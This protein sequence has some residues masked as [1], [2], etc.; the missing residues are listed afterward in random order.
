MK[1]NVKRTTSYCFVVLL[2][3]AA[4]FIVKTGLDAL[5]PGEG[6]Q[7]KRP[8][9][10]LPELAVG[11]FAFILNERQIEPWKFDYLV[12][13]IDES[14]TV[15]YEISTMRGLYTMPDMHWWRPGP[16][17][18]DFYPDMTRKLIGC[19]DSQVVMNDRYQWD[20]SGRSLHPNQVDDIPKAE[21]ELRSDE[22][23]LFK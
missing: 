23:V 11:Q 20:L 18:K 3:I 7:S 17:C 6:V 12:I 14:R 5:K 21:G 22:F 10:K 2:F 1:T 15:V 8:R 13:R 4:F 19:W 9:I 16:V